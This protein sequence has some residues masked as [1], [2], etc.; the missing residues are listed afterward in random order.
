MPS[1]FYQNYWDLVGDE[2]TSLVLHLLNSASLPA[3]LNHTFVTLIPKVKNM[4]YVLE[5]RPISLCNVLYKI[6]SKVLANRLK[7]ILPN[8]I[9]EHQSAFTKSR[10]ISDNILVAFESLHS[11]QRHTGKDEYMDIKLDM[12]KAYD[13]VEWP[14]LEV[15]M[16]KMGFD[17]RWVRLILIC[18]TIVS[19]SILINGEPKGMIMPS[20]G[21]R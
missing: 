6:F 11:M 17:D 21:I 4:E 9:I 12:S 14:Y 20:R 18:V 15:V 7:R 19:Y 1:L 5:F 2:V 3:N 10:L 16:R 8:I 13:K